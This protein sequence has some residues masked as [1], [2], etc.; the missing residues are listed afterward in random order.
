MRLTVNGLTVISMS[1]LAHKVRLNKLPV[2][3]RLQQVQQALQR[4]TWEDHYLEVTVHARWTWLTV[5]PIQ[6][7]SLAG[8]KKIQQPAF[9]WTIFNTKI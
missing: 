6:V 1:F 5:M 7:Y 4:T 2:L 8:E 3:N 9:H